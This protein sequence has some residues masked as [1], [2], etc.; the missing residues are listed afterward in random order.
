MVINSAHHHY[1]QQQQENF[2]STYQQQYYHQHHLSAPN[3]HDLSRAKPTTTTITS[4]D[5][6]DVSSTTATVLYDVIQPQPLSQSQISTPCATIQQIKNHLK[7]Q[8]SPIF[9]R[10]S[11]PNEQYLSPQHVIQTPSN[12]NDNRLNTQMSTIRY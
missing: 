6:N 3:N 1:Q 4:G 7:S 9:R 2:Q 11:I 10:Q 8:L 5:H 12:M